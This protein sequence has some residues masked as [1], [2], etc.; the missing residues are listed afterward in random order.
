MSI[1]EAHVSDFDAIWPIFQEVVEVGETSTY[2]RG[3]SKSEASHF[4]LD[5]P[6]KS[7]VYEKSGEI[8][9]A[10][11]LKTNQ[12]GPGSHVCNCFYMVASSA[13][14]QGIATQM[15]LHSQQMA[16]ELGYEALQFNY[17]S[18][19]NAQAVKLWIKLG[20]K[21]VG[22]IPRAC[23]HHGHKYTDVLIMYKW[24]KSEE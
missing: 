18:I 10:Y 21:T 16:L 4:W 8:L 13:R 23:K 24:L 17:V 1:R 2:S 19:S 12:P 20:F 3:V 6:R 5:V 15:C 22:R 14:G 7:F 9:G 11:S